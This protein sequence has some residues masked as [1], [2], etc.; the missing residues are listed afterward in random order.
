MR[1]ITTFLILALCGWLCST[2]HCDT[3]SEVLLREMSAKTGAAQTLSAV[4]TM[5]SRTENGDTNVETGKVFLQKP[6][7]AHIDLHITWQG[8]FSTLASDGRRVWQITDSPD[9]PNVYIQGEERDAYRII[10]ADAQ[11]RNIKLL[12]AFP[13]PYFFDPQQSPLA[14]F[15]T[16]FAVDKAGETR[17]VGKST[18][19]QQICDVV[20]L[21]V[22]QPHPYAMRVYIGADKLMRRV[23]VETPKTSN[24]RSVCC[25]EVD[26][27]DM[28]V[29]KPIA[30]STFAYELPK[31]ARMYVTPKPDV[32]LPVGS[33]APDILLRL[34]T[35][36]TLTLKEALRGKKALLLDFWFVECL[37]CRHEFPHFQ[38]LYNALKSKGLEIIAV[39]ALDEASV[40]RKAMKD[41]DI[42]KPTTFPVALAGPRDP[43]KILSKYAVK[44]YPTCYLIDA[45]GRILFATTGYDQ[46][47]GINDIKAVLAKLGVS[48]QSTDVQDAP[49]H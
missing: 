26:M 1:P 6:N 5:S 9:H 16:V 19:K 2:A 40:I 38:Q 44:G 14:L 23:V 41:L 21:S 10:P 11:G 46:K 37:G 22:V 12:Y 48:M 25:F 32:L 20:E 36:E 45:E 7:L 15:E 29:D 24:P 28:V 31:D 3:Q 17:Y 18:I 33:M 43:S 4:L 47:S 30:S 39:D 13:I 8:S 34:L 49:K 42:L 27:D 35:G